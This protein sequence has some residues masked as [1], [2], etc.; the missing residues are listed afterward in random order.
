MNSDTQGKLKSEYRGADWIKVDLHLHS[1]GVMT[2]SLPGGV[3]INSEEERRKIAKVYIDR[4][5]KSRIQVGAITDYNGIRQDWFDLIKNEAEKKGIIIFPGVELSIKLTG[6]K[7]GLHLLCIFEENINKEGLN[8]FLHSLDKNPQEPLLNGRDWRD[9]ESDEELENLIKKFRARYNCLLIFAHPKEAKGIL[10]TF[11]FSQ[12]ASYFMKL[13]PDAVEYINDSDKSRLLDTSELTEHI[14]EHLAV[15]ENSDPKSLEEIGG[16]MRDGKERA[17]F[18]KLSEFTLDAMKLALHDPEVRVRTYEAPIYQYDRISSLEVKGGTFLK[19]VQIQ[20]SPELNTFIGGRGVG[21]SAFIEAIRYA[22]DLPVYEG[23]STRV[24]FV[25]SV[26]GSGGEISLHVDRFFGKDKKSFV[27][28]KVIGKDTGVYENGTSVALSP[29]SLFQEGQYPVVIGQKE[30]YYLSITPAFQLKLIDDLIGSE[31]RKLQQDYWK[32]N[33]FLK[34]NGRKYISLKEKANKRF[35]YEQRLKTIEAQV[36]IFRDFGV[37]GKLRDWNDTIEDEERLKS[38][39]EKLKELDER[40]VEFFVG[41]EDDLQYAEDNLKRGKSKNKNILADATEEI[42][43]VRKTFEE[44]KKHLSSVVSDVQN[45]MGAL[46]QEWMK[47][48]S[49]IEIEVQKVK[50]ELAERNLEPDKLEALTK[51]K[52]KL[53]TLVAE[54]RKIDE[55]LKKV[56]YERNSLK[57][58]IVIKGKEIFD[59][60]MNQV[61]EINVALKGRLK[62]SVRYEEE[63]DDF[64]SKVK[65]LLR[66][67]KASDDAIQS[68][69]QPPNKLVDGILLSRYVQEG[70]TKLQSEFGLTA[71]MADRVVKWFEDLERLNLLETLFPEDKIEIFL[72]VD[73]EFRPLDKL[74]TGQKAS[75]LLLLL[76]VQDRI[77]ILDQPEEGLDNRF[78][79]E[80]VVKILRDLKMKRQL[81]IATHKANIPVLGDAELVVVL[82]W[83]NGECLIRNSGSIDR[84]SIRADV[85]SIMEGGEEAFRVRA[86]KY[87]G[88]Y[89]G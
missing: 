48:K 25:E 4:L 28:K 66:G 56:G 33:E 34:E 47:K 81:I 31:V 85:K 55:E 77:L 6:G 3:N 35:E 64:K 29:Q 82:E 89:Y 10:T 30:L 78:V 68:L 45:R 71:A 37:E 63:I 11:N 49:V 12:A 74:S 75:A 42:R 72:K 27:I 54:L 39:I 87:G 41:C 65:D 16:K 76:F 32:I 57:D 18:L 17:T 24:E 14:L 70:T 88:V 15:I 43:K 1:P 83:K 86:E 13:R 61:E 79:Y 9:I 21:K 2:F 52:M 59:T 44:I 73:K 53:S 62:I 80:D 36:K 58:Q 23:K 22:M 7:Y 20:F 46:F 50:R 26:V 84:N 19:D 51:E 5:E 8:T 60:R 67:S 40:V 69:I 38:S